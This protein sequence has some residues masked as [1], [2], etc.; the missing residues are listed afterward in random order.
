MGTESKLIS[1]SIIDED[2][3]ALN[4]IESLNVYGKEYV[5]DVSIE[6]M[7]VYFNYSEEN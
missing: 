1:F 5:F 3:D 2:I 6:E 4:R 7:M